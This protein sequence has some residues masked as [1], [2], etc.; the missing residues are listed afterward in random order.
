MQI[1]RR[2][3][4]TPIWGAE[5]GIRGFY[6][7]AGSFFSPKRLSTSVDASTIHYFDPGIGAIVW[8]PTKIIRYYPEQTQV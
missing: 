2:K 1:V 5:E 6:S 4:E 8:D 7:E 3:G